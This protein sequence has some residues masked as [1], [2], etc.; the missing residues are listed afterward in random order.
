MSIFKLA[1][2]DFS[3]RITQYFVGFTVS[4]F[5]TRLLSPAEFGT[6]GIVLSIVALSSIFVDA[7]FRAAIIQKRDTT[8]VQLSTVFYLN[9]VMSIVLIS[10]FYLLAYPIEKFYQI[11][12]LSIYII[13]TSSIFFFNALALVPGGLL[14]KKLALKSISIVNAV[15]ALLSGIIAIWL[16]YFEYKVWT[17]VAQQ[18]A[19]SF[20]V[21]VGLYIASGWFP[22]VSFSL[23]S[24]KSHW[25][26]GSRLL[27]SGLMESIY[28]RL[29]V[30]IIG[31]IFRIE[32]LGFYNRSLALNDL[33]KNFSTST[34]VSVLFPF[35]ARIQEDI[36]KTRE[37]FKKSLG[38]ISLLV[39]F[40]IGWLF[41][42]SYDIVVI[43]FTKRWAPVA[44]YFRLMAVVGFVYP[45]SALM[46]GLIKARGD[47]KANLKMA[48]IKKSILFPTFLFFFFGGIYL[49]LIARAVA[50]S[51]G[52]VV[53]AI[54]VRREIGVALKTQ[55]WIISNYG[56]VAISGILITAV[57]TYW[58]QSV[59]SHFVVA[60]II[61][62]IFYLTVNYGLKLSGFEELRDKI[63]NTLIK[64]SVIKN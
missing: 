64:G 41:L 2:W 33:I 15:S 9:V 30:L 1:I 6:F 43:L 5:L 4:V 53:N 51:V 31:K 29:D 44:A 13:F 12:S 23:R 46:V 14:Q 11:E 34:T 55:F 10:V 35:F 36:E 39:F 54:Y 49:F 3:G 38:L 52:L 56:G 48:L 27:L 26:F 59:Y 21:L 62:T 24:V 32:T 8:Q 40:L 17:L 18:L 42:T 7:G 57:L 25:R 50:T 37:Y 28:T 45:I 16:A 60:S 47:S 22:S 19:S 58:I 63:N 61:Y 20:F